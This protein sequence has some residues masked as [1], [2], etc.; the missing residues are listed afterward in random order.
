MRSLLVRMVALW[1]A[2][3]LVGC[4]STRQ[5]S[6]PPLDVDRPGVEDSGSPEA[7]PGSALFRE[8]NPNAWESLLADSVEDT[9]STEGAIVAVVEAQPPDVSVV[10]VE[11][12]LGSRVDVLDYYRVV[13]ALAR[14]RP[15]DSVQAKFEQLQPDGTVI[16]TTLWF[17]HDNRLVLSE[18]RGTHP[19]AM[20]TAFVV[21]EIDEMEPDRIAKI[22]A[23]IVPVPKMGKPAAE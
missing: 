5:P 3:A 18:G 14:A 16:L 20:V 22:A 23:G 9:L 2:L 19:G 7:A 15:D 1:A 12:P 10:K 8:A 17:E 6:P 13:D 11:V 21:G 4:A